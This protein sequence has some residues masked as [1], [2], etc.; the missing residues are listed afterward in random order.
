MGKTEHHYDIQFWTIRKND[1][2]PPPPCFG[3]QKRTGP[4]AFYILAQ[5]NAQSTKPDKSCQRFL[6]IFFFLRPNQLR[7]AWAST[8]GIT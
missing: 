3:R 5:Q 2:T 6:R 7:T 8:Y 4:T 1:N